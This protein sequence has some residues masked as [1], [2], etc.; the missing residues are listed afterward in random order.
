[1]F[2]YFRFMDKHGFP[3]D[4]THISIIRPV[5]HEE[6]YFNRKG[7]HS[8]NVLAICDVNL[9]ILYL[10]ASFGGAA[11]DSFIWSQSPIK[12]YMEHL[13]VE[14]ER[15]WLL[16]SYFVYRRFWF[17][18]KAIY[19]DANLK[20]SRRVT[21]RLLQKTPL[22]Y[23]QRCGTVF[24]GDE[25]AMAVLNVTPIATL[26][27]NKSWENSKGFK[28]NGKERKCLILDYRMRKM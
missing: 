24:W 1:M 19:D 2:Y 16:V 22:Q 17:S 27:P 14:G 21:G 18:T 9:N 11:H 26:Y 13:H 7:Y 20:S 12:A 4:G 8:L 6:A 25:G 15:N 23:A 28:G 10:D 5:D 3:G